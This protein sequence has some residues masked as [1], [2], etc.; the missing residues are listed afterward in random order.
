MNKTRVKFLNSNNNHE[1]DLMVHCPSPSRYA[2]D[3]DQGRWNGWDLFLVVFNILPYWFS[4]CVEHT[5]LFNPTYASVSSVHENTC[6]NIIFAFSNST[7][8]HSYNLGLRYGIPFPWKIGRAR[9][10]VGYRGKFFNY[11]KNINMIMSSITVLYLGLP[12]TVYINLY[13]QIYDLKQTTAVRKH[14]N[15]QVP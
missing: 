7:T 14:R 12:Q 9:I 11:L 4:S 10:L 1:T 15:I 5:S 3:N 6:K 13:E 2:V 8:I